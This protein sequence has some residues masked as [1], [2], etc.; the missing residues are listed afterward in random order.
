M[1]PVFKLSLVLAVCT[2]GALQA[3]PMA[4]A[5]AFTFSET[6]AITA[7]SIASATGPTSVAGAVASLNGTAASAGSFAAQTSSGPLAASIAMGT[8]NAY[9]TSVRVG[10]G[11]SGET[12]CD[13][14]TGQLQASCIAE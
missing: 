10:T 4:T 5:Q 13:P 6:G 8:T 7:Y 2:A 1:A 14:V 12:I 3:E 9:E 11:L